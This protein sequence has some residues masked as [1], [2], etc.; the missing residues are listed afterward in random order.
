M[1][2]VVVDDDGGSIFGTLEYGAEE[3]AGP[4]RR[5]FTTPTGADIETLCAAHGVPATTARSAEELGELVGRPS[6]GIRVIRVPVDGAARRSAGQ[7]AR[8]A[9]VASLAD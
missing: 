4:M 1:T 5:I 6:A 9:V 2:I 3:L 7:R 8:D